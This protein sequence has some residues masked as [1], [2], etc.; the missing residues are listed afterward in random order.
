[1]YDRPEF[2]DTLSI[3][4][5]IHPELITPIGAAVL[6]WNHL[7]QLRIQQIDRLYKSGKGYASS[8]FNFAYSFFRLKSDEKV[9][10]T[11][12]L[13]QAYTNLSKILSSTREMVEEMALAIIHTPPAEG[14]SDQDRKQMIN[15]FNEAL[16]MYPILPDDANTT[17]EVE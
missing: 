1:M 12:E 5:I 11:K 16:T 15:R 9:T 3:V 10:K 17:I 2:I 7:D 8:A 6:V 4:A 13:E 14:A